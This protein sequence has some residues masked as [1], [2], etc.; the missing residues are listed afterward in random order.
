[1]NNTEAEVRINVI[2]QE[3]RQY[4][5]SAEKKCRK[6]ILGQILF[7]LD[8][9]VWIWRCQIYCSILQYHDGKICNQGNLKHTAGQFGIRDP[10]NLPLE[11]VHA[12]L[13][14]CKEQCEYFR[15]HGHRY[16]RKHLQNWLKHAREEDN[17]TAEKAILAIINHKRDRARLKSLKA[18]MKYQRGRSVQVVQVEQEDGV[19]REYKGQED[20]HFAIQSN[21]HRKRFYLAKLAP[22]CAG[23]LQEEF[24]Y[25][26]DTNL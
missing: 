4:M 2:D 13:H 21:I 19:I 10:L 11:E 24:G 20:V 8:A 6:I 16:R 1:M 7:S 26:A 25:N 9:A 23:T 18:A 14:V 3:G 12:R 15:Q 5:M 22:I 17:K